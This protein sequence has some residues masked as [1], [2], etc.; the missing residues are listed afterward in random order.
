M[1][2]KESCS[3]SSWLVAGVGSSCLWWGC[4]GAGGRCPWYCSVVVA[5]A[6]ITNQQFFRLTTTSY[7]TT[8]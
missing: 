6:M 8:S 1:L 5:E 4:R 2:R 7:T 3:S